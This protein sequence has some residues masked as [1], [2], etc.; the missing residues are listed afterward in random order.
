MRRA[1]RL[2]VDVH[3]LAEDAD[4]LVAGIE[5]DRADLHVDP[6]AVL[7][8]EH[9]LLVGGLDLADDLLRERPPERGCVS[10]GATTE[11]NCRPVTSPTTR[12]PAGL[13]QRMI[14]W[15]SIT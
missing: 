4:D 14:P 3:D 1:V 12:L 8:E 6:V 2:V 10:S 9:H 5:R 11:V 7:L 15:L 13:T